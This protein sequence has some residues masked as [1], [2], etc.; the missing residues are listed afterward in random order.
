MRYGDWLTLRPAPT[1]PE[2]ALHQ[3]DDLEG[4]WRATGAEA[5][6][7]WAFAWLGGQALARYVLD[8]PTLVRGRR[9]LDLASG[10]GL[11]AL[12][13]AR[14]GAAGVTAVD[15]DPQ[16]AVVTVANAAANG[17]GVLA[18]TAD[19]LDAPP[20]AVDLVLAADVLYDRAMAPRVL[21]WLRAA[22]VAGV[23]VLLADPGRD[24]LP[25]SGLTEVA[26]YVLEADLTL[27]GLRRRRVAIYRP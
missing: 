18:A 1:V 13:A 5:P 10:S 11:V 7:Y 24:F 16:A 26:S 4:L 27:E 25:Q 22:T 23:T 8:E 20:P 2:L 15:I 12:A 21:H 17:L 19:L 9:V 3:A 14:A 6:P